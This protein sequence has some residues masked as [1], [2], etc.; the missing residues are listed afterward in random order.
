MVLKK[1]HRLA[2]GLCLICVVLLLM[3]TA[4]VVNA[5]VPSIDQVYQ[6]A[7]SGH[8]PQAE[9]MTKQVLDAYPNNARAHYVMAQI[10]AAEG[11]TSEARNYLEEADRLKPGLPFANPQSVAN[12]ERRI[13][14]EGRLGAVT[15]P[16]T[17]Q[18]HWWWLVAGAIIFFIVLRALRARRAA[19][20]TYGDRPVT[21]GSVGPGPSAMGGYSGWGGG[22]LLGSVLAGLGFGAGVAAGERVVD[23]LLGGEQSNDPM[24]DSQQP[25]SGGGDLGGDDFG[26]QPGGSSSGGWGDGGDQANASPDDDFG[27]GDS[28]DGGWDDSSGG[29]GDVNI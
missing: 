15:H 25:L 7:R 26:V 19:S 29:G 18:V 11:R 9:A 2:G 20:S 22:G 10:L 1:E 27:A 12:L 28:S 4:A 5:G 16:S 23:R 21:A 17:N 24:P 6:A 14:S 8:L 13:N 3:A